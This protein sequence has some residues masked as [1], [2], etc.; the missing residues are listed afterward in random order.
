MSH[1]IKHCLN[2]NSVTITFHSFT[3]IFSAQAI[4]IADNHSRAVNLLSLIRG[5]LCT[6]CVCKKIEDTVELGKRQVLLCHLFNTTPLYHL[7]TLTSAI[8]SSPSPLSYN[9]LHGT[10]TTW[11]TMIPCS[12]LVVIPALAIQAPPVAYLVCYQR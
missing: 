7:I 11:S 8:T 10:S 2:L 4:A 6:S 3:A 1:S 9:F 12:I 5:V